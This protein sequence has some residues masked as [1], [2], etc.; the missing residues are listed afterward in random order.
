M[1][2]LE[3]APSSLTSLEVAEQ[4]L[5]QQAEGS[6]APCTLSMAKVL[7]GLSSLRSLSGP[8]RTTTANISLSTAL[9][10]CLL[11]PW[12]GKR[13]SWMDD[14]RQI[15]RVAAITHPEQLGSVLAAT[16]SQDCSAV[17]IHTNISASRRCW[18]ETSLSCGHT[19][20]TYIQ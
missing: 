15:M 6:E 13:D 9:F 7:Q 16:S 12:Q 10:L 19:S 2:I 4:T 18:R 8:A 1:S 11:H 3:Q 17:Q 14:D 20:L 5:K